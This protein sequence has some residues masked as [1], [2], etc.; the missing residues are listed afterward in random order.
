MRKNVEEAC[1]RSKMT[2]KLVRWSQL[3]MT[4][5]QVET[6]NRER[7]IKFHLPAVLIKNTAKVRGLQISSANCK[8]ANLGT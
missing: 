8:S 5:P 1:L 4:L 6:L 7:E 2:A 3:H